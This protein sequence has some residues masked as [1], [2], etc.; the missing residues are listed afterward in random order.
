MDDDVVETSQ[1]AEVAPLDSAE[2]SE[3]VTSEGDLDK[4]VDSN[5]L[6]SPAPALAA[7]GSSPYSSASTG[8]YYELASR[9]VDNSVFPVDYLFLRDGQYSYILYVGDIDFN[10]RVATAHDVSFTRWS[11]YDSSYDFVETHG[12]TSINIDC[13]NY[14]CFASATGWPAL[15]VS[16]SFQTY[17]LSFF[18][19]VSLCCYVL[20]KV[21]NFCMRRSDNAGTN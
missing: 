15:D 7:V 8:T 17:L 13:G 6:S 16:T 14:T 21:F 12:T 5:S 19:L 3:Q 1:S 4:N 2:S 10:G 11:R 18:M 20:A 9:V